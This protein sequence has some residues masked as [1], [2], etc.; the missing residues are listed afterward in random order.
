[1]DPLRFAAAA[2][3]ATGLALILFP[4]LVVQLLFGTDITGPGV[5]TARI[6]GLALISLAIAC[7]PESASRTGRARTA[8]L[9]YNALATIYLGALATGGELRGVLLWPAVVLHLGVTVWLS[10]ARTPGAPAK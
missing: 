6:A 3:A 4:R 9:V 5:A 7:W 8:M 1:M 10:R 2:E